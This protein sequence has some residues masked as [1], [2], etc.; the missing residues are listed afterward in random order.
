ME[1]NKKVKKPFYKRWWF[2]AIVAFLVIGMFSSIDEEEMAEDDGSAEEASAAEEPDN[3]EEQERSANEDVAMQSMTIEYDELQDSFSD[4]VSV[5]GTMTIDDVPSAQLDPYILLYDSEERLVDVT[6]GVNSEDTADGFFA[7]FSDVPDGEYTVKAYLSCLSSFEAM[8]NEFGNTCSGL[9]NIDT[10]NE[11]VEFGYLP[12]SYALYEDYHLTVANGSEVDAISEVEHLLYEVTYHL[13]D[14]QMLVED[15]EQRPTDELANHIAGDMTLVAY[16]MQAI[17][18][19][20]LSSDELSGAEAIKE[21][22][23]NA[24]EWFTTI[25][26][27]LDRESVTSSSVQN[28]RELQ[29]QLH[30]YA[31]VNGIEIHVHRF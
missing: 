2:F 10:E 19:I 13:E 23:V 15:F 16:M 22:N 11:V 18:G 24:E 28:L 14:L 9:T 1:Q 7:V 27:E 3:S 31:V 25:G 21:V 26:E 8:S 20:T 4:L 30:D 29:T 6:F 5:H 17:E 12:N